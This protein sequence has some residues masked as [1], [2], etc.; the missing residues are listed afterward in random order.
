MKRYDLTAFD[1]MAPSSD[2]AWVYHEDAEARIAEL[3]AQLAEAQADA[4]LCRK[5]IN[6]LLSWCEEIAGDNSDKDAAAHEMAT[7]KQA[8]DA[9]REGE[10]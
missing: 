3:E 6:G 10:G 5:A 1:N 7:T 8:L 9:M 2:G 4:D